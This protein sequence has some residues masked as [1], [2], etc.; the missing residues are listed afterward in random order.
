M[1]VLMFLMRTTLTLRDEL[2]EL[3][4]AE[5]ERTGK[6]MK[7]TVNELLLEALKARKQAPKRR[8]YRTNPVDMGLAA[9]I[10]PLKLNGLVD[11]LDTGPF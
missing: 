10:D 7:E 5:R 1:T 3:L 11:E 2:G 4:D 8:E 9:G 6:S